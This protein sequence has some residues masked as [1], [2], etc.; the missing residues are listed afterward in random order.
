MPLKERRIRILKLETRENL[1]ESFG[2]R[3]KNDKK[4]ARWRVCRGKKRLSMFFF[5][6]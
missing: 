3:R 4:R 5:V 2:E 1:G 6:F